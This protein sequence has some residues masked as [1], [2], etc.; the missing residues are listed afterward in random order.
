M[1][2][3]CRL[4]FFLS[5]FLLQT[6]I[7]YAQTYTVAGIVVDDKGAPMMSVNIYIRET[8]E[9]TSSREDGSFDFKTTVKGEITLCAQMLGFTPAYM[10]GEA[11]G[12]GRVH[13]VLHPQNVALQEVF[14]TAGNYRLQGSSKWKEMSPVSIATTAG[15]VGD[16]YNGIALLPGVQAAGESG[17]LMVRGGDSREAQTFIDEMHVL[18]PYTYTPENSAARGRYSPFLFE[19]INFS[20]GGFS[21]DYSQSLSS[22]LPLTTKDESP[23]TKIGVSLLS[24]G[25]GGGGTKAWANSSLS[26]N[27]DYQNIGPYNKLFPDSYDWINPYQRISGESQFRKTLANKGIW[28]TYLAYDRTSFAQHTS[29]AFNP[30]NRRLDFEEDNLYLNST[31]RK[32]LGK[33]YKF[34]AG[35]AISSNKKRMDGARLASDALKETESE[36]HLKI[37]AEKRYSNLYKLTAGAESMLRRDSLSYMYPP[38]ILT[39][40]EISHS[41][42]SLFLINDFNLSAS[43]QGNVS[44]R[45]EQTSLND[46]WQIL[47]RASLTYKMNDFYLSAIAGL[48]QQLP[49]NSFLLRN[50]DLSAER[51]WQY[52]LGAYHEANGKTFRLEVYN[53]K[54][55]NLATNL[56]SIYTS[57]GYGYARGIDLFLNDREVVKNLEYMLAYSY[58]DSKR[59]YGDYPAEAMP[60]YAT[61]HNLSLALKYWVQPIRSTIGI[62]D[63]YASGRPYHNPNEEG[64]MQHT[65][66]PYNSLDLSISFLLNKKVIIHASASNI[67]GRNNVYNYTYSS[68]R[69]ED[70]AFAGSPVNAPRNSF[71]MIGIFITLSGNTAYDVSN[72]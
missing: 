5:V 72:F 47:P 68:S 59:K 54:Y 18:S 58:N 41:I 43:L 38:A 24:V 20:S 37:K 13:L 32:T 61:R 62:T 60:Q 21:S 40:G 14:V 25:M 45:V 48:Y 44:A 57:D 1:K 26:F 36:I 39:G 8:L 3:H 30:I 65:T 15:A 46:H 70:G 53:K 19:G 52:I 27:G 34:F 69:G 10:K 33:G 56:N 28:K 67:L 66:S 11:S 71:F 64:F 29:E 55:H 49:E 23:V 51:C 22:V 9:G 4:L 16:I 50:Q 7:S 42:N 63:R 2:T 6:A 17:K 35:V 12:M 31:F